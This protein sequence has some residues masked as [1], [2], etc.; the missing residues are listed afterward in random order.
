[1]LVTERED[2]KETLDELERRNL[3]LIPLDDQRQWYRYHHLFADVL[4]AHLMEAQPD[5]VAALHGG[6]ASGMNKMVCSPM[7]SAMRWP[8]RIS[9]ERRPWSN[10]QFQKCAG[11]DRGPRSRS[12]AG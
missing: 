9:S 7:R 1:M 2:G 11:I 4:H 12:L 8:P 5:Q 3:F 6:Q 10:W